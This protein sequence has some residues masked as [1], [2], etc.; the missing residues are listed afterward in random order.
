MNYSGLRQLIE[1]L[2]KDC[3]WVEASRLRYAVPVRSILLGRQA[4]SKAGSILTWCFDASLLKFDKS[5]E[6]S[7]YE[8]DSVFLRPNLMPLNARI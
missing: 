6:R 2:Y 1:L 5:L 4:Q 7:I 3:M 8:M